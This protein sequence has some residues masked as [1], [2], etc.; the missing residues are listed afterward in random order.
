ILLTR[1]QQLRYTS[2]GSL[3]ERLKAFPIAIN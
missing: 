1:C 2:A 3:R